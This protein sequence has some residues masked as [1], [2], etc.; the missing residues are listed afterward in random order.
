M[1]AVG[2]SGPGMLAML[3]CGS[4]LLLGLSVVGNGRRA[5]PAAD[6]LAS[7]RLTADD[8]GAALFAAHDL[9]P[10]ATVT[11][12]LQV[13]Y[14][15]PAG[16]GL[17]RLAVA[18][19]AGPLAPSLSV[20]V[21]VGTGGGFA[22]CAGFTGAPVYTG[23]L[24]GLGAGTDDT[25]GVPAGWAPDGDGTRTYRITVTVLPD[26]AERQSATATF[27]WLF[28][29]DPSPPPT[30]PPSPP[31]QAASPPPPAANP[32]PP[33]MSLPPP[34]AASP[35][36][37]AASP[38]SAPATAPATGGSPKPRGSRGAPAPARPGGS[39]GHPAGPIAA[40]TQTVQH[41]L[42]DTAA[43]GTRVA[44][45]G[46]I[47]AVFLVILLGFLAGQRYLDRGDPKLA[48]APMWPVPYLTF[49][50]GTADPPVGE[51]P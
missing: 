2:R 30:H 38:S 6:V 3:V 24:A 36:P 1:V 9:A 17:V 39:A 25:V 14:A 27:R 46:Q 7:V 23:D 20:A 10:G 26:A 15:G 11:R 44:R 49:E 33:A 50:P 5:A 18:D 43:V 32:P 21:A 19:L 28:V 29:E 4:V 16:A 35:S 40:L 34:P 41:A 47:P 42:H 8:G 45:R 31:P 13:R 12:C 48:L 37:P 22:S 51:K